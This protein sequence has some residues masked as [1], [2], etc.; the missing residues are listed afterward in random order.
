MYG[1]WLVSV[2]GLFLLLLFLLLVVDVGLFNFIFILFR[3]HVGYLQVERALYRWSSSCF[4]NW[5]SEQMV[6]ALWSRVPITL[7]LDGSVWWLSHCR[8]KS[9]CVGF[10]KTVLLRLPSSS[11]ITNTSRN[12]RDP[13]SL[14]SSQVNWICWST[15]LMWSK[16]A[17]L[18]DDSRIVNVSSTYLLQ[19]E[20]GW[21]DVLMAFFSNSSIKRLATIGLMGEPMAAPSCCW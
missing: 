7:Y 15:E 12:G 8:Y 21:G 13:S 5:G 19:K 6:L 17:I 4:N 10:L 16:K 18:C 1:F 14:C 20:G 11:G 2:P 3:A 9:V